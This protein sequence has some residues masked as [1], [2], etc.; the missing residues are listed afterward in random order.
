[1]RHAIGVGVA[2]N[3]STVFL[4]GAQ[5]AQIEIAADLLDVRREHAERDLRCG[6]VMRRAQRAA[7]EVRH[8]YGFTG[9]GAI[10]IGDVA[11]K[12]PRM[13][14]GNAAGCLPVDADFVHRMACKRAI[15]SAVAGCVENRRIML[16][17]VNGLMMNIWAVAGDASMGMRLDQ[18]SSF[19]K[20]PISG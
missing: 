10:A 14:G 2:H 12:N 13:A 18:V 4:G 5:T 20:P 15:R 17:P 11:R 3:R 9:L 19:C 7:A 16:W 8:L 1:M 6:A